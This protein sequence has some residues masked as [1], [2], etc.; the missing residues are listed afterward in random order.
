MPSG[1]PTLPITTL[2]LEHDT[3]DA[4][5]TVQ[6]LFESIE[7]PVDFRDLFAPLLAREY[8]RH[9]GIDRLAVRMQTHEKRQR[10]EA[11]RRAAAES[12][13]S[14]PATPISDPPAPFQWRGHQLN[15][16]F[17]TGTK[18]IRWGDATDEDFVTVIK[19]SWSYVRQAKASLATYE[20]NID[21]Y[22]AARS[23]LRETGFR[24]LNELRANES[25]IAS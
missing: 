14:F 24:T 11:Q 21:L 19:W 12:E 10:W 8:N 4:D 3:G 15:D 25:G 22:E 18:H 20:A 23:D 16:V 9:A 1:R 6:S 5:A 7:L 17:F 2:L 13:R